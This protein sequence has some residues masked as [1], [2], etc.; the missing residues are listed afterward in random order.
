LRGLAAMTSR[1]PGA[2]LRRASGQSKS[3]GFLR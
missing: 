3:S 2:R 1:A